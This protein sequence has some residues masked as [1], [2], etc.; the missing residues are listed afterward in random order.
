[1]FRAA[2]FR[3]VASLVVASIAKVCF[4][5]DQDH[6]GSRKGTWFGRGFLSLYC[7]YCLSTFVPSVSYIH[8]S[9]HAEFFSRTTPHGAKRTTRASDPAAIIELSYRW[10]E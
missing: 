9:F 7:S 5:P 10:S 2:P 3:T 8:P 4:G 1:M 6:S